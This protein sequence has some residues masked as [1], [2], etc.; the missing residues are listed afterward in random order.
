MKNYLPANQSAI[1]HYSGTI[2]KITGNILLS[3]KEK[4][5]ANLSFP[6]TSDINLPTCSIVLNANTNSHP[7]ISDGL[8]NLLHTL[9]N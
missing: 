7:P 8:Q 6:P 1:P 3:R 4:T 9:D 5:D 2:P